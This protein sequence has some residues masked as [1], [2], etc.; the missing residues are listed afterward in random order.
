MKVGKTT[1]ET[2][3]RRWRSEE[4]A[5]TNKKNRA[6]KG[7]WTEQQGTLILEDAEQL[8]PL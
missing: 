7:L 5:H 3:Q 4:T 6:R 8:I 1:C 2:Q